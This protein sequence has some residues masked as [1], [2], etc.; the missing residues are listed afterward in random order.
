MTSRTRDGPCAGCGWSLSRLLIDPSDHTRSF[1]ILDRPPYVDGITLL[2]L[3]L[4]GKTIDTAAVVL[5]IEAPLFGELYRPLETGLLL[6]I[7]CQ[8]AV[9][10][11]LPAYPVDD[12]G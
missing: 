11:Y 10:A 4:H 9:P 3:T 7:P 6:E 5:A 1:K 8:E 2:L 12:L